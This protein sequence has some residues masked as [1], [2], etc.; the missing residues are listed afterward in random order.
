MKIN[1]FNPR[2]MLD[3]ARGFTFDPRE[4]VPQHLRNQFRVDVHWNSISIVR[5]ADGREIRLSRNNG[6]YVQDMVSCFDYYFSSVLPTEI[7]EGTSNRQVVDFSSGHDQHIVG[8]DD[9]PIHCPSLAEPYMTCQQYLEFAQLA[10]GDVVIDLGAYSALT[11]IAFSKAVGPAGKVLAVEP[12]AKNRA[13]CMINIERHRKASKLENITMFPVAVGGK[14]GHITFSSEGSMGSAHANIVGTHRGKV[15]S[16]ECKTLGQLVAEAGVSKV[17]FIKMDIEGSETEAVAASEELFRRFQPRI[18]VE[19][20][21]VAG[22]STLDP[23]RAL[24]DGFGYE[25]SVIEQYGV[26]VPLLTAMP[27]VRQAG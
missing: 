7:R 16:V 13:S 8:F 17:D 1:L 20:H 12:D 27:R 23:V 15:V 21:A 10:P 9:F 5:L 19:P 24:L 25:C 11:S 14:S 4:L 6:V 26:A 2:V 18:I 3:L 22:G